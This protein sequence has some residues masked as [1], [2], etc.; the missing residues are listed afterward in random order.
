MGNYSLAYYSAV[1]LANDMKHIHIHAKGKL[2]DTIHSICNEYYEKA[3]SEAD[4][5]AELA[6]EKEETIIN[7]S[8]LL[9][10]INYKPTSYGNYDFE[11]AMFTINDCIVKYLKVLTNLRNKTD[12]PSAQSLLDDIIRYWKKEVKYKIRQRLLDYE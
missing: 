1:A 4:T 2:F 5:L 9:D 8:Y 12:D 10:E 6:I 7:S 11:L 3:N